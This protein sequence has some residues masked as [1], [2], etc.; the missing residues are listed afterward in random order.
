M[1]LLED[2]IEAWDEYRDQ[3]LKVNDKDMPQDVHF[4][5]YE[6]VEVTVENKMVPMIWVLK[7]DRAY[8]VK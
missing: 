4:S 1:H 2:D 5:R 3:V 8:R 6:R 7:Q